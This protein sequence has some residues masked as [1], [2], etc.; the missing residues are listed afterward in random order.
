MVEKAQDTLMVCV[1]C[2][3]PTTSAKQPEPPPGQVLFEQICEKLTLSGQQELLNVQPVRCMGACS[4]ACVV[5]FAAHNKL[6]FVLSE[7]SATDSVSDLLQFSEQYVACADGKVPY[8]KR[9]EAV[10]KGIHAVLPP[11]KS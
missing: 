4:R 8:Q 2:R 5:A 10:K 7:L 3:Y 1:L 6:T 9:P 11:L